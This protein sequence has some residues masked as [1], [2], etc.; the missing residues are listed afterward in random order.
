[1]IGQVEGGQA[2][3]E[4][5]LT[6]PRGQFAR[7]FEHLAALAR[8]P[9]FTLA[10]IAGNLAGGGYHEVYVHAKLMLVDDAW[11]TI[12]STNVADRSFREDTELNASFWH[13]P[14]VR[15]LRE[16]LLLEHLGEPTGAL[17]LRAALARA[18]Q[19]A[20]E[21]A[22]RKERGEPLAGLVYALDPSRYGL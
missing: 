19:L 7:L 8:H 1:M 18:Q 6:D 20:R 10:A 9:G 11:A 16:A 5:H 12:G 15:A 17:E 2:R 21:N 22:A 4:R 3:A 13:A 14:S